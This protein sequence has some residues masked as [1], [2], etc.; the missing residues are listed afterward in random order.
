MG[1]MNF[2]IGE[3][4][5]KVPVVSDRQATLEG[6]IAATIKGKEEKVNVRVQSAKVGNRPGS[7][8]IESGSEGTIGYLFKKKQEENRG[9]NTSR[10]PV[11]LK[12]QGEEGISGQYTVQWSRRN[13]RRSGAD[14]YTLCPVTA[15]EDKFFNKKYKPKADP[16]PQPAQ[17][18]KPQNKDKDFGVSEAAQREM[19]NRQ[20]RE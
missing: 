11:T 2:L 1:F 3:S 7:Y 13:R 5:F 9:L 4:N 12:I 6:T 16:K 20:Y 10:L 18:Q 17:P 8:A 15:E 14:A 19:D